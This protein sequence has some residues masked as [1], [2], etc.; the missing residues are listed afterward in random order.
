MVFEQ[1]VA[2][3]DKEGFA[4]M[5]AGLSHGTLLAAGG[6]NFPDKPIWEGGKKIWYDHIYALEKPGGSWKKLDQKLPHPLAYG[7]SVSYG[8]KLICIGGDS[9]NEPS[10]EVFAIEYLDGRAV[11]TP[12]A[13]LPRPV[14]MACGA[15]VG[16]TVYVAGGLGR[17]GATEAMETFYAL[18]LS[19]QSSGWKP[20][21]TWPGPGRH[22][23]VA[24][25]RDGAFYLFGG[26]ELTL[27]E[28]GKPK[29]KVP[30]LSDAY[31]YL[32]GGGDN[33]EGRWEPLATAPRGLAAA[34]SPA[35]PLDGRGFAIPGGVD[36]STN[37]IELSKVTSLPHH[38]FIYD[39]KGDSWRLLTEALPAGSSRV[40][41]P[42]VAYDGG[43]AIVS[44]ERAPCRRS[45]QVYLAKPR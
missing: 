9:G 16:S 38:L 34:P 36:G 2:L 13:Q 45:P 44:G 25:S 6:T 40:A 14:T 29:P 20:L 32:P 39:A 3:P 42:A 7:V 5:F 10:K 28:D 24:G 17:Q 30:Y 1:L 41:A 22:L 19:A 11:I 8:D 27:G 12:L 21:P 33:G 43:W 31:R 26:I 18:D 15:L 23:S 37:H 4:A 35:I